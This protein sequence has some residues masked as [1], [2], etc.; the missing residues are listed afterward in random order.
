VIISW[1][2]LRLLVVSGVREPLVYPAFPLSGFR[3]GLVRAM[4]GVNQRVV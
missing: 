2:L 3:S 4:A 1:C